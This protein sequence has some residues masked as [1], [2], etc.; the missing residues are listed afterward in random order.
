MPQLNKVKRKLY[1]S[2]CYGQYYDNS[3]FY[4]FY[5]ELNGKYNAENASRRLRRDFKNQTI[6]ITKVDVER[7][8]CEMP[9]EEFIL[10]STVTDRKVI[11]NE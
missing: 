1:V 7:L 4:D 9:T 11:E 10:K 3:E 2:K 5:A 6:L 8:I